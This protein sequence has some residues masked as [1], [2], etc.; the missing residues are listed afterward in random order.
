[1][2]YPFLVPK[3]YSQLDVDN[4]G[5]YQSFFN[6]SPSHKVRCQ[7]QIAKVFFL[8]RLSLSLLLPSLFLLLLFA[9]VVG[10]VA[11]TAVDVVDKV[12]PWCLDF[13]PGWG[14]FSNLKLVNFF[15]LIFN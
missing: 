9:I 2:K 12:H 14:S 15:Y 4:A 6:K 1:M 11:V 8:H 3:S 5:H 13:H 7:V 10:V